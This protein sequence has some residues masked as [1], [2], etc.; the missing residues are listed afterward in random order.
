MARAEES[1]F[2]CSQVIFLCA[3]LRERVTEL[4]AKVKKSK[5]VRKYRAHS[6]SRS[7]RPTGTCTAVA[8]DPGIREFDSIYMTV[9]PSMPRLIDVP[10]PP[11]SSPSNDSSLYINHQ[12]CPPIPLASADSGSCYPTDPDPESNT[13]DTH[14]QT[15]DLIVLTA[16]PS[17]PS[18]PR[19]L[20]VS[21]PQSSSLMAKT[22]RANTRFATVIAR[23][24]E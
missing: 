16:P 5:S 12:E 2:K 23:V 20:D 19:L 24:Y 13:H 17:L 6:N 14:A 15:S 10:L 4:E 11:S 1:E 22:E 18:S 8:H 9:P 7:R 3:A 21:L